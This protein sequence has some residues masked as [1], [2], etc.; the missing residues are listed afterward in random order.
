MESDPI[1]VWKA[2]CI[3][4]GLL[5]GVG[6]SRFNLTIKLKQVGQRMNRD[7]YRVMMKLEFAKDLRLGSS[8]RW[9]ATPKI[10]QSCNRM[11]II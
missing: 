5:E 6:C 2:F 7:K 4:K 9:I 10:S 8:S 1:K 3:N 11:V